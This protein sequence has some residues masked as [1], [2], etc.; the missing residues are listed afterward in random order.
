[1][2]QIALLALL[3]VFMMWHISDCHASPDYQYTYATIGM[4]KNGNLT[5]CSTCWDDAGELG[6]II[7][8]G[9]MWVWKQH[10]I[11][12]VYWHDSQLMAGKPFNDK[13]ESQVDFYGVQYRY[14]IKRW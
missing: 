14:I 11:G 2:K 4:G 9:H 5:G 8:A 7:G 13:D 3:A 1:M 10:E 12:I 6:T